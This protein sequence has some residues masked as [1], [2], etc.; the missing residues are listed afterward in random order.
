MLPILFPQMLKKEATRLGN[1]ALLATLPGRMALLLIL[2]LIL[3]F[4]KTVSYYFQIKLVKHNLKD[5]ACR[6]CRFYDF[7]IRKS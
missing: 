2:L 4:H 7:R 6:R 5:T 1:A 3:V